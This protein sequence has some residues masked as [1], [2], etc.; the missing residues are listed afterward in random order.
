MYY[1]DIALFPVADEKAS[2][3]IKGVYM[4]TRGG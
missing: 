4:H 3:R 2:V 1:Y